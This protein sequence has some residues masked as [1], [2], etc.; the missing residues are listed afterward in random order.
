MSGFSDVRK[1]QHFFSDLFFGHCSDTL[2]TRGNTVAPTRGRKNH[3]NSLKRTSD[4][5]EKLQDSFFGSAGTV[6]AWPGP[7]SASRLGDLEFGHG[8]WS[9][10]SG[11]WVVTVSCDFPTRGCLCIHASRQSFPHVRG[12]WMDCGWSKIHL[13]QI[14]S[15]PCRIHVL[16]LE[17]STSHADS[18]R[19]AE[20]FGPIDLV[21]T[22]GL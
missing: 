1:T 21:R 13:C 22:R 3:H 5:P 8:P 4:N 2:S 17:L 12:S 10:T 6:S 14:L 7:L 16:W 15:H 9:S 11:C 19:H 18:S 20:R